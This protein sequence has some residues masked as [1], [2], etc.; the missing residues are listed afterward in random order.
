MS[1]NHEEEETAVSPELNTS[2]NT[3]DDR[4][5]SAGT[6]SAWVSIQTP[7]RTRTVNLRSLAASGRTAAAGGDPE[8]MLDAMLK[9]EGSSRK[10][11]SPSR[12]AESIAAKGGYRS[13]I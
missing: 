13:N 9:G 2:G 3:A 11:S 1:S 5:S 12:T 8:E 7:R 10:R 4:A 6:S